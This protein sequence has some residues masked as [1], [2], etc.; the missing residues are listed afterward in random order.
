M[1]QHGKLARH[2]R[3]ATN[4][5]VT[6]LLVVLKEGVLAVPVLLSERKE[7]RVVE[8]RLVGAQFQQLRVRG[9]VRYSV[10]VA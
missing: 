7:S 8:E 4:A 10:E 1:D 6:D 5:G 9:I 2:M 3:R